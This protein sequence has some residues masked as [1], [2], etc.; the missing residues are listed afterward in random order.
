MM[1]IEENEARLAEN[2]KLIKEQIMTGLVRDI[3]RK[4]KEKGFVRRDAIAVL[5]RAEE[6]ILKDMF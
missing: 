5:H 2:E 1:L 3:C 6:E 4:M